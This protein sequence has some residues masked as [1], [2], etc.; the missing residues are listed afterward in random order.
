M[1]F[2]EI[3]RLGRL[4][5]LPTKKLSSLEINKKYKITQL[6]EIKTKF[7]NRVYIEIENSFGVFLPPRISTFILT[8]EGY[9][10][11][12]KIE[13]QKKNIYLLYFGGSVNKVEFSHEE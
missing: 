8:K 11:D 7:G 5:F 6:K 10:E 13:C 1:D 2:Q 12:L 9:L 4:E 3:N